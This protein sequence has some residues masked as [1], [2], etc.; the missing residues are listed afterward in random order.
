MKFQTNL[1]F[2]LASGTT[3]CLAQTAN[4][5]IVKNA[6]NDSVNNIHCAYVTH[7]PAITKG[8]YIKVK[9]IKKGHASISSIFCAAPDSMPVMNIPQYQKMKYQSGEIINWQ[10]SQCFNDDCTT[11]KPLFDDQFSITKSGNK[12]SSSPKNIAEITLDPGYGI[13]CVP[14]SDRRVKPLKYHTMNSSLQKRIDDAALMIDSLPYALEETADLLHRMRQIARQV[15][16]SGD[17]T[18]DAKFQRLKREIEISQEVSTFD[19][20]KLIR[21]GTVSLHFGGW[22]NNNSSLSLTIPLPPTDIY[23]L[24]IAWASVDDVTRAAYAIASLNEAIAT[25]EDA[26]NSD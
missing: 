11:S 10:F 24:Q 4:A 8:K 17:T 9:E 26:I 14:D 12:L 21:K 23:S 2:A 13:D 5:Y 6:C 15:V 7:D 25:V 19:G 22:W 16:S 3:L 18:L 1:L 20:L